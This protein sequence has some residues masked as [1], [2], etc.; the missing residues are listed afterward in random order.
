MPR[1]ASSSWCVPRSRIRPLCSTRI[2][3]TFWIVESRCAITIEVRPRISTR[4][5]SWISCSVSVSTD[6]VASSRISTRGSWASARA[7]DSSCF[8]PTDSVEPRS[9]TS[10]S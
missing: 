5:A 2:W 4:S 10:V 9:V 1:R 8:W 6:E 7:K 3:S